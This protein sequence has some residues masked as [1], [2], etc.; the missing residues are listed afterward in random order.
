[1]RLIGGNISDSGVKRV[2]DGSAFNVGGGAAEAPAVM[3]LGTAGTAGTFSNIVDCDSPQVAR[4]IHTQHGAV[5]W[6]DNSKGYFFADNGDSYK[7][8]YCHL[9]FNSSTGALATENSLVDLGSDLTIASG[10]SIEVVRVSSTRCLVFHLDVSSPRRTQMLVYDISSDTVSKHGSIQT[11]NHKFDDA[12]SFSYWAAAVIDSDYVA[13]FTEE[14]AGK[15]S[16]F[17]FKYT[18]TQSVGSEATADDGAEGANYAQGKASYDSDGSKLYNCTGVWTVYEWTTSGTTLTYSDFLGQ[19]TT[20]Y[21]DLPSHYNANATKHFRHDIEPGRYL[22]IYNNNPF[23]HP[24]DS[25]T[26]DGGG[27]LC[28]G[29]TSSTNTS[30]QSIVPGIYFDPYNFN[31]YTHITNYGWGFVSIDYDSD[32]NWEKFVWVG[33]VD[34]NN[35]GLMPINFNWKTLEVVTPTTAQCKNLGMGTNGYGDHTPVVFKTGDNGKAIFVITQN[36]GT[37]VAYNYMPIS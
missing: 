10:D 31:A 35:A 13:V 15:A 2:S 29:A 18:T 12:G 5:D 6:G 1:M 19:N 24:I 4:R 32:T 22:S 28:V 33:K 9:E 11:K 21:L 7:L 20:A 23:K 17:I 14:A 37:G 3:T 8:K 34:A 25:T 26:G 36:T 16:G 27:L 30:N